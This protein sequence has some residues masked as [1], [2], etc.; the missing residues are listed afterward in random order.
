MQLK[1]LPAQIAKIKTLKS[2][3]LRAQELT[4]VPWQAIC[5]VWYRESFSVASPKTPGGP[6]QFDPPLHDNVMYGLLNTFAPSLTK[7]QMKELVRRGINDF[8]AGAVLCACWLRL[9]AKA[10]ITP[11]STM[12]DIKDAFWGYNGRAF[13]D[14]DHSF[15]VM[16]GFDDKHMNMH[17]V[18]TV[19]NGKGGR[20]HI[21]TTDKRPG[22][23]TVY[24]QLLEEK[25]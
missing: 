24:R 13:H 18:G 8:A 14:A 2:V 6:Y 11:K 21:D 22:A 12:E 25:V 9:H 23:L 3:F 15:Y 17:I 7:E 4:G 5:A 1:L 16:N 10:K 20:K 19:P